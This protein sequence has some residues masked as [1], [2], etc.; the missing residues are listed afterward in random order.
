MNITT[1]PPPTKLN[2]LFSI[3]CKTA[4]LTFLFCLSHHLLKNAYS[5]LLIIL[6]I[7][8]YL[9]ELYLILLYYNFFTIQIYI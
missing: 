7:N 1:H 4:C 6:K 3:K 2:C 8:L 9:L 5:A